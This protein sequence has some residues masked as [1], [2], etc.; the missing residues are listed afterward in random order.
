MKLLLTTVGFFFTAALTAQDEVISPILNNPHVQQKT[1]KLKAAG[2]SIDSTFIYN[3]DTL[4]LP[5]WDDFS[6]NKFMPY[7]AGYA[8]ANVTS[9]WYYRLMNNTNTIPQNPSFIF[10]DSSHAYHDSISVVG[11]IPT[12][13]TTYFTTPN[14]VWVNELNTYP[15]QGQ[16]RTLY[17]ECY[18]LIDSIIDGIPD[19]DQDTVF[20][21]GSP[22]FVQDSANVFFVD[23]TNPNT[24]WVDIY[25]YHNYRYA[26]NP[27]SLGVAT[28]DGVD[29]NGW[30]YD[31]GNTSAHESADVLTSRPIN[32]AGKINVYL[33]FLYQ[34]EGYG[35]APEVEDSLILEWWLPDSNAW[36]PS[37]WYTLGAVTNDVWDT[38]HY[39]V[40]TAALDNGF[41]FRFRNWASTSGN[42]DHWHIDYVNLKD[43]DLPTVSNFSDLA[44]SEPIHSILDTYTAVP[45]DH[46]I[47]AIASEKMLDE[48]KVRVYNSNI[49]ATNY[50]NGGL[51]IRYGGIL[52]GGSPYV[53]ANPGITGEWTGNWEVGMNK[54]PYALASNYT[55]D[56]G[57]TAGPQAAFDIKLN[58]DAAV[59]GSNIYDVNDTT[60]LVQKFDNYY[61]Y[62]DGSAEAAY[63][64]TG[65]HALLA[66][67]FTAYEE[68]SLTG[69]L[70]HWVPSVDDHS[71]KAFL[72]TIWDDNAGQP[73]N[74]IYQDDY[75]NTH[76]PEYSG[77]INGFR[78]YT[79]MNGQYVDVPQTF[80]V[81]WEQIE[82]VSMNIGLDWNTDNSDKIFRNTSGTW[83]TSSYDASILMR[84]VFSTAL[85]YTL[86]TDE[87]KQP[88]E[89][90][91]TVYPNPADDQV[92][93]RINATDF[94]A[95]LIDISGRRVLSVTN[96]TQL[97]LSD[98]NA[99]IYIIDI[100]DANGVS[101]YSG[102]LIKE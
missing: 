39:A 42:L 72:L 78:Y 14:Q 91:V 77:A 52:Q 80:Y 3:I 16:L 38:V 83:A 96:E 102:K 92:T 45:W 15:V 84:P 29:E 32:L 18:V 24:I 47:N 5:V 93:I 73:G 63:G 56:Q 89:V 51:E 43:N 6:I 48:L 94:T 30:P 81:G 25:A 36:F 99:G 60:Y 13:S 8:D 85:N 12:T 49:T 75:F 86:G 87:E 101:L 17:Q 66:Y 34:A 7:D 53:L 33:T 40:P 9:Q 11:G 27:W 100:R 65:S 4:D 64:I 97:D 26:V 50:A 58:I 46:F 31:W 62:D 1:L 98:L 20:Y 76:H 68:D 90:A 70:M 69:V 82:S 59:S 2:N 95:V 54:Y 55:F 88:E 74:I 19:P 35:N 67:K 71:D 44:I 23:Y 10:C 41:R 22:D 61:S 21:T 57:V 37:G 79:F 28:L